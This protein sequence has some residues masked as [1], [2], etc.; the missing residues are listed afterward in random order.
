[1]EQNNKKITSL[2]AKLKQAPLEVSFQQVQQWILQAKLEQKP[3]AKRANWLAY[4]LG[5][6]RN[7]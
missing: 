1:M 5:R 2:L 6:E 4:W 3:V 7:N